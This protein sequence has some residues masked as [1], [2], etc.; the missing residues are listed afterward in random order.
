VAPAGHYAVITATDAIPP[1][2]ALAESLSIARG[3]H[4]IDAFNLARK[5]N[6]ILDT[7]LTAQQ[8]AALRIA[9]EQRG[10]DAVEVPMTYFT[11]LGPHYRIINADCLAD[12]FEI[13]PIEGP[14]FSI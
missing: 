8:A 4:R 14:R 12:R 7:E 9:L 1:D 5:A 2:T 10:V 11:L 3:V 6:Y 13:E